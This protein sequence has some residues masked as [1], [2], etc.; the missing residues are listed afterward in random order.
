MENLKKWSNFI[1]EAFS[2]LLLKFP[3]EKQQEL[4]DNSK[5]FKIILI[6]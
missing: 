3:Y 2:S 5:D 4:R 1:Y 6:F